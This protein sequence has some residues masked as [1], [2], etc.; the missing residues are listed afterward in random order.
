MS[1]D[2]SEKWA[3]TI[4][5]VN[6]LCCARLKFCIHLLFH[7]GPGSSVAIPTELRDGRSRI[8]FRWGRDFPPFQTDPGIHP[9]SCTM[10]TESFPGAEAAEA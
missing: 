5:F 9:A 3:E 2:G 7:G 1:D 6:K 4:H 10:G 8:E